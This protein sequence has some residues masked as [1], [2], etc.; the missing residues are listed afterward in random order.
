M[1]MDMSELAR[2]AQI[3]AEVPTDQRTVHQFFLLLS[4]SLTQEYAP[5]APCTVASITRL[6]FVCL[7]NSPHSFEHHKKKPHNKGI[8]FCRQSSVPRIFLYKLLFKRIYMRTS[9]LCLSAF[10]LPLI[11]AAAPLSPRQAIDSGASSP[12]TSPTLAT[13][14]S[15]VSARPPA[16]TANASEIV[17]PT[18]ADPN[19][20]FPEAFDRILSTNFSSVSCPSF[21]T[22]LYAEFL[23]YSSS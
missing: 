23:T 2:N 16:G 21:F 13:F 17:D 14:P 3:A 10:S 22:Q 1:Y 5:Y 18:L 11:S 20:E 19:W 4:N 15:S 9:F 7:S 8:P 12:A 6:C